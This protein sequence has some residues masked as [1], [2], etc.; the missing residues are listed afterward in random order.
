MLLYFVIWTPMFCASVLIPYDDC[1]T[2]NVP[3]LVEFYKKYVVRE[4]ITR[5]IENTQGED[6]VEPFCYCHSKPYV[7]CDDLHCN[8]K[9][10]HFT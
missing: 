8:Y 7:R 10:I 3:M 5:A 9:W 6:S 1:F 2:K 4:L